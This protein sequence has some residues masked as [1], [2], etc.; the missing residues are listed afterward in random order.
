MHSAV[1][2]LTLTT[3]RSRALQGAEQ[4]LG[5]AILRMLLAGESDHARAVAGDLYG[6]LLD[7]PFRLLIAESAVPAGT[8]LL[9]E[10]M[11]AAAS[12]SGE[13]LL[14]VPEGE[15]LVVLAADG[16]EAAA[17]A[18]P[19]PAPR[20]TGRCARRVRPT[21]TWSS[22]CPRRPARSPSPPRTSRPNRPCPSRAA[23]AGPW[24][25]TRSS[26][27]ALSCRSSPTTPYGPSRTGC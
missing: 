15:R 20:T 11:E 14:M 2:L 24:S 13:S 9:A 19:T 18:P 8:D 23:G 26:R 3:A 5:A 12:R 21:P 1:A 27:P 22:A 7:A 17:R 4:R 10:S 25:S 6:G 16:G